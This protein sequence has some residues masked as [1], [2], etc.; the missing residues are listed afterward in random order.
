MS[1]TTP[2]TVPPTPGLPERPTKRVV[3]VGMGTENAALLED[4]TSAREYV[5]ES[6]TS[7]EGLDDL[8]AD[9][10]AVSLAV[11]DVTS[12]TTRVQRL[13]RTL[14]EQDVP[15]LLLTTQLSPLFESRLRH[16]PGLTVR[17][18]P[19]RQTELVQLVRSLSAC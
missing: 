19:T 6:V 3:T 15:V 9:A 14:H 2:E 12:V 1:P 13:C 5:L 16:A 8:L 10:R 4:T 18:K 7:S 11:V 17:Q